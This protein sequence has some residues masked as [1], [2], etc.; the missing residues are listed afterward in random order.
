[1]RTIFPLKPLL[2]PTHE[3]HIRVECIYTE[4]VYSFCLGMC[5]SEEIIRLCN[6]LITA[7]DRTRIKILYKLGRIYML[8]NKHKN[9][10]T[11]TFPCRRASA[12]KV[13]IIHSS[14]RYKRYP[15]L[16]CNKPPGYM[17]L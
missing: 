13:N 8:V 7:Y 5:D 17:F 2:Y 11:H 4:L 16:S 3:T 14:R 12:W 9:I 6:Q 1:M 15:F 10:N